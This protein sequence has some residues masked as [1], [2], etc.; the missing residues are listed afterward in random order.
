[1]RS[2]EATSATVV[3]RPQRPPSPRRL[4]IAIKNHLELAPRANDKSRFKA[5]I[6]EGGEGMSGGVGSAI[7]ERTDRLGSCV[8]G[9]SRRGCNSG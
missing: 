4:P 8:V 5:A 1:M 2:R 3:R 6:G 7:E 9:P